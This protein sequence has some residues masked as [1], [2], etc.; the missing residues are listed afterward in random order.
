MLLNA[1]SEKS[2][3]KY[4]TIR[5][6]FFAFHERFRVF[7]DK[8]IAGFMGDAVQK[9]WRNGCLNAQNNLTVF[10]FHLFVISF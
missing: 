10:L 6:L 9:K 5:S 3:T 2:D 1:K 8:Y 7:R 4:P